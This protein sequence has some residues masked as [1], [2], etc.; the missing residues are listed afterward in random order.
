MG[1]LNKKAG[2]EITSAP[3][4]THSESANQSIFNNCCGKS[5]CCRKV[6]NE[7]N[8]ELC[9]FYTTLPAQLFIYPI[10]IHLF[11]KI[12]VLNGFLLFLSASFMKYFNHLR[13]TWHFKLLNL[14]RVSC[15]I[16]ISFRL[17]TFNNKRL[18]RILNVDKPFYITNREKTLYK[19]KINK[20]IEISSKCKNGKIRCWHIYTKRFKIIYTSNSAYFQGYYSIYLV[21]FKCTY[22]QILYK[23]KIYLIN[24]FYLI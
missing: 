19:I 18:H 1:A 21:I 24:T 23:P 3:S 9:L 14:K 16:I 8:L 22:N 17:S 12:A 11:R 4:P 20:L 13:I 6:R 5:N 2:P 15:G 7:S 10:L